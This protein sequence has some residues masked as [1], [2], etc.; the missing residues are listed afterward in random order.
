[1]KGLSRLKSRQAPYLVHLEVQVYFTSF[2][3]HL[4]PSRPPQT[5]GE[6]RLM[7]MGV[8]AVRQL[9][10]REPPLSAGVGQDFRL[11]AGFWQM[12]GQQSLTE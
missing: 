8:I 9:T 12:V 5:V 6:T 1:V 11:D 7:D 2:L 4:L 3:Q 10:H